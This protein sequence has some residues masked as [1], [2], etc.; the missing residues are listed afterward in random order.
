MS[1]ERRNLPPLEASNP[2]STRF[3]RPG[4]LVYRFPAEGSVPGLLERLADCGWRSEIV[5]PHGSGKSTLLRTLI[6]E[7]TALGI[8]VT[9]WTL[10]QGARRLP[11]LDAQEVEWFP[12]SAVETPG[13]PEVAKLWMVDGAEQLSTVEWWRL[14]GSCWWNRRGLLVTTHRPLGLPL[15]YRTTTNAALAWQLVDDLL[16]ADRKRI[17]RADVEEAFR[18]QQGDIREMLLAL[19]DVYQQRQ[20]RDELRNEG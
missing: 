14:R 9:L 4:S 2:F 15:L 18:S 12:P 6:P 5:G 13:R 10:R 19:F 20:P 7:L 11:R 16:P 1:D 3:I 17:G 8:H